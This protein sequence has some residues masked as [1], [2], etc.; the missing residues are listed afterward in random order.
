M[1]SIGGIDS[2]PEPL[3]LNRSR[4]GP[5]GLGDRTTGG[6]FKHAQELELALSTDR[7]YITHWASFSVFYLS[8]LFVFIYLIP[9]T[10]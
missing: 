4:Q 9:I 3:C 10:L 6:K 1:L 8:Y 5:S 2:G 7:Y